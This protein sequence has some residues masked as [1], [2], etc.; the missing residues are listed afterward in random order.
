MKNCFRIINLFA[1]LTLAVSV[2]AQISRPGYPHKVARSVPSVMLN[3]ALKMLGTPYVAHTL[4]I[5]APNEKLVPNTH[6]VDCTTF[7]EVVLA[8]S[9]CRDANDSTE[10]LHNLQRIRY[11]DGIINGYTSRLHYTTEWVMNGTKHGFL[12]DITALYSKDTLPVRLSYMSTH[13]ESYRQLAHSPENIAFMA[14]C[15]KRLSRQT[16]HYIPKD[17]L[18]D[19]GFTWIHDGDIILLVTNINGLD[20]SHLGI[21]IYRKGILHLLHASSVGKKV[22][23]QPESL[24]RQMAKNSQWLGIRVVRMNK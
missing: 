23:I 14:D 16:V 6:E 5:N 9:L 8:R 18:P 2:C 12:T 4:E 13:P 11:R 19:E 24:R 17:K 1:C 7:V 20:N 3:H 22:M 10:F 21:A 15:E